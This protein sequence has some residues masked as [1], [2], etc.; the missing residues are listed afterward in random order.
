MKSIA[1]WSTTIGLIGSAVL[2]SALSFTT[3]ALALPDN[4]IL[5]IINQVP[6]FTVADQEGAPLVAAVDNEGS[7]EKVA[8]VF[9][10]QSD[11]QA[12][13]ERLKQQNPE[14]GDQVNVVPVSMGEIYKLN[15]ENQ[16]Q[17]DGLDFAFVPMQDQV[18]SALTLLRQQGQ[19]VEQFNGVPLFVAKGGSG[20]GYLTIRQGEEQVIPFF[21]EKEQI[22]QMV[23]RFKE[24][25]PDIAS[26]IEVQVVPLE[27]V[28][29]KLQQSED[30]QLGNILLIPS[31]ES[32]EF[33]QQQQQ[34]A[35]DEQQSQ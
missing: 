29:A 17:Q 7:Q 34:P 9:I 23:E 15:Q 14:L 28:I 33:L 20:Q 21:F 1:R 16:D 31:R 6:V 30:Q 25:Q 18:Q 35:Q 13:I 10:S 32:I 26:S 27:G 4:Q 5:Q 24:Q 22:Q 3:Q 2:G 11:A 19:N 12:F 8:G